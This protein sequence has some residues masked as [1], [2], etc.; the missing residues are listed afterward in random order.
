MKPLKISILL[1][2][3]MSIISTLSF[4]HDIAVK[5]ADGVTI[6][7]NYLDKENGSLEVTYEDWHNSSYNSSN[8]V[9]PES[10]VFS[11]KTYTVT[12]IGE[13]A[14]YDCS[15]LASITIPNSVTS[16]GDDAFRYCSNLTSITIPNSVTSIGRYAFEWT[17]WYDNQ[18][19]GMI[20]INKVAYKYKGT[21][22]DN[23]IIEIQDG[24]IS[25]AGVAFDGCSG[26]TSVI[27]PNSVTCIG[28]HAFLGCSG[29]ASISIPN[30]VTSIGSHAFSGC[31]GLASITIPNSVMSIGDNAFYSCSGLTTLN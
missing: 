24:T 2:M 15:N 20:Y 28:S 4:A 30:S 23:T 18:P 21:M 13:S 25:I 6:Y 14:F 9:I 29:L 27:I 31:S 22:P 1:T 10:F 5:N 17:A 16:I 11:G 26:L 12:S 8:I 7:Y 3:F 19:D